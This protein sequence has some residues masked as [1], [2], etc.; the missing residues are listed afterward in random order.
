[1]RARACTH[2]YKLFVSLRNTGL[3]AG[4]KFA[5]TTT[6]HSSKSLYGSCDSP[7][8]LLYVGIS[9]IHAAGQMVVTRTD[10]FCLHQLRSYSA[11]LLETVS[12]RLF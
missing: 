12:V 10:L 9:S 7:A 1:M 6:P 4:A 2:T 11:A 5:N 8:L 3:P